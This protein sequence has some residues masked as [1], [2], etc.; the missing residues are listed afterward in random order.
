MKDKKY[1]IILICI[2][3]IFIVLGTFHTNSWFDETYLVALMNK[4]FIDILKIAITD[5]LSI[6]YY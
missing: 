2:G 6:L 1:Y 3:L 5:V 4:K